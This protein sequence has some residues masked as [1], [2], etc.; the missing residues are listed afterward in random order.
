MKRRCF[1]VVLAATIAAGACDDAPVDPLDPRTDVTSLLSS[2]VASADR[3]LLAMPG[4]LH[5][6]V[7]RVY[8][9]RGMAAAR[10]LALELRLLHEQAQASRSDGDGD[11]GT[12]EL[13]RLQAEE[14]RI[15]LQVFGN[16]VAGRMVDAVHAESYQIA[17]SI[18]QAEAAGRP[19]QNARE[20]LS[21]IHVLVAEGRASLE[22]GDAASALAAAGRAASEAARARRD[23]AS[24]TRLPNLA[25]LFDEA[26]AQ[27]RSNDPD[28]AEQIVAKYAALHRAVNQAIQ[29]TNRDRAH[30]TVDVLRRDKIQFV[31]TVLGSA[32]V[33]RTLLTVSAAQVEIAADVAAA[34]AAGHD[35]LRLQRMLQTARDLHGRA[36]RALTSGDA[37]KAL[38]LGSHAADLINAVRL[39]LP[40]Y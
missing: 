33:E 29:S 38:D 16:P 32:A 28:T 34:D 24:A 23:L 19:V 3:S 35:V 31:L 2:D 36:D 17:Q 20:A 25:T 14:I 15:I 10:A 21:R 6:A 12:A 5:A 40:S 13:Q 9:D 30:A 27:L 1:A 8:T 26:V 18:A 7:R 37:A 22:F 11:T 4:L 39:A